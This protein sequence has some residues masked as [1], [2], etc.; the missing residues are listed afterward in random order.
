MEAA[1]G[2]SIETVKG[3]LDETVADELIEF[4]TGMGALTEVQGRQRLP[5]VL[6]VLRDA[7]GNIAGVNS[8][9]MGR[10]APLGNQAFDT[11]R[12]LLA[13]SADLPAN[14][15]AL[16]QKAWQLLSSSRE[17]GEREASLGMLVLV[18]DPAVQRAYPAAVWPQTGLMHAGY[19]P[20][21]VQM[22]VRYYE[23]VRLQEVSA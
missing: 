6:S 11:Y 23:G 4:W 2:F 20:E 1:P 22:R 14:R 16:I 9:L 18:P 3:H 13:P 5:Q 8:A 7:E 17:A 19:T 21:G 12:S 15:V 10:V